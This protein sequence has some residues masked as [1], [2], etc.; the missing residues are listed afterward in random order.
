MIISWVNI[1]LWVVNWFSSFII[2]STFTISWLSSVKKTFPSFMLSLIVSLCTNETKKKIQFVII[3]YCHYSFYSQITPFLAKGNPLQVW[4]LFPWLWPQLVFEGFF[5]QSIIKEISQAHFLL[6]LP[7]KQESAFF[8]KG[9]M[10][11]IS[12]LLSCFVRL[13]LDPVNT[14]FCQ[15]AQWQALSVDGTGG[16]LQER[17]FS[18][19]LVSYLF[20]PPVE[21]MPGLCKDTQCHSLSG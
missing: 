1:T 16:T 12:L 11:P 18:C 10:P 5:L 3:H 4:F 19:W 7:K 6:I 21:Q 20:A 8:P 14:F 15:L 17:S 9:P 13:E 2:P